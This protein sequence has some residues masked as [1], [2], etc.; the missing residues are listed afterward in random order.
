MAEPLDRIFLR[1]SAAKLEQLSGRIADCLARLSHEQVWARGGS[2]E[3]AVGNLVLHRCGNLRQWIGSGVGSL[4]D[5]RVRDAEF[6]ARDAPVD[7]LRARLEDAVRQAVAIIG[8]VSA[9][10]LAERIVVQ[11]HDVTVLEAIAHVVEHFSH[12]AGQILFATKQLTGADLGYYRHLGDP[13]IR[14]L[15]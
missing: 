9:S 7:E 5:V 1:F 13:K 2:N 11:N 14:K 8:G 3:N 15:P 12:H 4:P 6:A 10:R